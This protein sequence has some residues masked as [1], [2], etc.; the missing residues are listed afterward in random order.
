MGVEADVISQDMDFDDYKVIVA[1][2]MYLLHEG[3][4]ERLAKFVNKG[5]Q[6]VASYFTGYVDESTLA[7]LGGFPGQN[8][9]ELFGV[10]AEEIDSLYPTES[11]YIINSY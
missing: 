8:L 10:I 11:N 4:G 1:P 3:V 2:M 9:K 7:Y 5:G 6:L